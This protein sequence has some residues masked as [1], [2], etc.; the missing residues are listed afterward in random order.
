MEGGWDKILTASYVWKYILKYDDKYIPKRDMNIIKSA[1]ALGNTIS[2][3]NINSFSM[4]IQEYYYSS[5]RTLNL[6]VDMEKCDSILYD[7]GFIDAYGM[8]SEEMGIGFLTEHNLWIDALKN[9]PNKVMENTFLNAKMMVE[10]ILY[11]QQNRYTC[12]C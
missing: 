6:V 8:S 2:S 4:G 5:S 12:Y 11:M 10:G 3:D 7:K 1:I 9:S